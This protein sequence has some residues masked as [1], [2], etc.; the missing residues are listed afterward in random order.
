MRRGLSQARPQLLPDLRFTFHGSSERS[1][2][3]AQGRAGEK[4]DFFSILLE[5]SGEDEVRDTSEESRRRQRHHPSQ[6]HVTHGR[7]AH[8]VPVFEQ[9][10]S[11]NAGPANISGGAGKSERTGKENQS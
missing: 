4:S 6:D 11:D 7:P 3:A 2:S 5:N 10:D 8:T 9:A 1:E